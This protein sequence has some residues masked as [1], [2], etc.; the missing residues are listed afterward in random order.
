MLGSNND[1]VDRVLSQALDAIAFRQRVTANNMAN[2]NTPGFKR[3]TVPF[4]QWLERAM[5]SNTNL[6]ISRTHAGHLTPRGGNYQPSVEIDRNT[7]LR[8]D[9]NNV[10]IEREAAQ[11]A[12]DTL[13]YN[14]VITQVNRRIS[15]LRSVIHDGR[16]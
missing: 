3:G 10:D 16:R 9:G 7:T 5:S 4:E 8:N 12:K 1:R 11:E 6:P 13:L 2:V 14:A 15:A